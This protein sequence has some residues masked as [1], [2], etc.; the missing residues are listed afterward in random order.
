MGLNLKS[1]ETHQ[2]AKELAAITGESMTKAVTAAI[3]ERLAAERRRRD[4]DKLVEDVMAI[5]RRCASRPVCDPRPAD[6]I[7]YGNCRRPR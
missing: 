4:L 1:E 7:L 6:D 5:G 2:L 3:R